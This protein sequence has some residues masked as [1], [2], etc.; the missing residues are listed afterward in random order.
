[1]LFEMGR[2]DDAERQVAAIAESAKRAPQSVA[3]FLLETKE[4][5]LLMLRG[6]LRTA[7]THA[8]AALAEAVEHQ[9]GDYER[10]AAASNL[11]LILVDQRRS[12]EA[13]EQLE[14]ALVIGERLHYAPDTL[15][16]YQVPLAEALRHTGDPQ[17][18]SELVKTATAAIAKF[19]AHVL[20]RKRIAALR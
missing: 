14:E 5:I 2:L 20:L 3:T 18:A 4:P 1:L 12:R 8:R 15:A 19:P 16:E 9:R 11:G 10:V 6:D 17:R 13:R 7:E